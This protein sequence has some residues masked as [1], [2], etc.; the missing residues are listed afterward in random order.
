MKVAILGAGAVGRATA[1]VLCSRNHEVILWSPSGRSTMAFGAG[2]ALLATGALSGSFRPT[3][4]RTCENAI[5]VAEVVL[6]ALPCA[7]HRK[8]MDMIAP[9]LHPDQTVIISSHCSL[10]AI[11]LA[12]L[13]SA[14]H[15]TVPIVALGTTVTYSRSDGPAGVHIWF[16]RERIECATLPAAESAA[17]VALCETLFGKRFAG[18]TDV[19]A[20][21]LSNV[22][23]QAH[24]AMI[25]ANFTRMERAERWHP[26]AYATEAV[27]RFAVA[28]DRE[29]LATAAAFAAPVHTFAEFLHFTYHVPHG[30]VA[31][32]FKAMHALGDDDMAGPATLESRWITQDMPFIIVPVIQL[33]GVAGTSAR[34]HQAGVEVLSALYGRDLCAGNDILPAF[35]LHMLRVSDVRA[36]A[37]SA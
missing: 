29:R 18:L 31:D 15:V 30:P 35:G 6:L 33:A 23:G 28:L 25:L 5:D 1:A 37:Q 11:Y 21:T 19:I 3:V 32:M 8:I 9:L 12:R 10:G 2:E 24:L 34:L 20:A 7:A 26:F 14:R 16:V 4:A 27:S 22:N 36:L 17:G 13:L